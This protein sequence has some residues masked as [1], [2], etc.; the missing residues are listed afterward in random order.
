MTNRSIENTIKRFESE[1][2]KR[3]HSFHFEARG[4]LYF[5]TT[6]IT[7]HKPVIASRLGNRLTLPGLK[8]EKYGSVGRLLD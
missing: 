7:F 4:P 8:I 2:I 5:F 1:V 3:K 6:A